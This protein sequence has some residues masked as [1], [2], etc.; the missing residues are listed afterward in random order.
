MKSNIA[1]VGLDYNMV[2][3]IAVALAADLDMFYLSI[4]DLIKYN[5][6]KE[7]VLLKAGE[8][9][10]NHQIKKLAISASEYE[11]TII[12]CPYDLFLNEEIWTKLNNSCALVFIN[13]KKEYLEKLNESKPLTEKNDVALL[14]YEEIG[15]QLSNMCNIEVVY[16]GKDIKK[17]INKLKKELAKFNGA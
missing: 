16:N 4:N 13:S 5:L 14:V 1:L 7:D 17:I 8:E 9:Y 10:L 3:D 15:S 6:N 11:N 2:N 12:N